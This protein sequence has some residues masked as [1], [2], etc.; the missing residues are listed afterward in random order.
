[1]NCAARFLHAGFYRRQGKMLT[2]KQPMARFMPVSFL[3]LRAIVAAPAPEDDSANRALTYQARF[4]FAALDPM[5]KLEEALFAVRIDVVGNRRS[6]QRDCLAQ[7]FLNCTM[8][9]AQLI[10]RQRYCAT[11]RTNPCPKQGFVSVDVAH[12]AQQ[13]LIQ[14]RA[15]NRSLAASKQGY[16]LF[17]GNFQ[18]FD[19]AGVEFTTNHTQF[20]EHSWVDKAQFT[21][22]CESRDEMRVLENFF[23]WLRDQEPP[24]HPE[25]NDP[26][27]ICGFRAGTPARLDPRHVGRFRFRK[28]R[29]I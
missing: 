13:L 23:F 21:T 6:T 26:L 27:G 20:P 25:M 22:R 8:E 4:A 19:S 17:L 10:S 18:G 1:M 28:T 5:L 7:H 29:R 16:E 9:L 2:A 11:A 12:A 3:A 15:L 24:R 14:Q